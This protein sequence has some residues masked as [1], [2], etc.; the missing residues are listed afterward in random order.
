MYRIVIDDERT[1]DMP[2]SETLYCRSSNEGI[3]DLILADA[4]DELW[5][6]HDLGGDDTGMKVVDFLCEKAFHG[7]PIQIGM[8]FVHS[9]NPVGSDAMVRSLERYGYNVKRVGLP[10]GK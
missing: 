10:G 3:H 2:I 8:I 9:Q 4:V 1:F 5:L 7:T 6:D